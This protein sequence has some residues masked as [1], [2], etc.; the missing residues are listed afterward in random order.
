MEA[1]IIAIV[2]HKGGVGKT[3]TAVNL[4]ASLATFEKKVLL[5]D[6]DPQANATSHFDVNAEEG[7]NIYLSIR[8]D[9][10]ELPIVKLNDCL[11]LVPSSLD[12]SAAEI[13]ITSKISRETILHKLIKPL[14][15][16]YDY[17]I[18][19]CP[20]SLG[21][22]TINALATSQKT[23]IPVDFGTF[24]V[25]GMA[26][27]IDIIQAVKENI[28]DDL[29]EN[30]ILLTKYDPRMNMHKD[31]LSSIRETLE[32]RT[33]DT[34]IR[35]NIALNEAAYNN[36]PIV[37]YSPQ[38]NGAIDYLKLAEEIINTKF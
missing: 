7:N 31:M 12:L 33:F 30:C 26:K 17:I 6:L 5:V 2:N 16:K 4:T 20:P 15:S 13:E 8:G 27:L 36:K 14:R 29:S 23:I 34:I 3:T 32:E 37:E 22:L 28:N 38:S 24:A 35:T 25:I 18:I 10:K 9:L 11:D 19:D 1:K 21:L